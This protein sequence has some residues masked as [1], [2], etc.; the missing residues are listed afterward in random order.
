MIGYKEYLKDNFLQKQ[1]KDKI[2]YVSQNNR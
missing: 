1:N 2:L